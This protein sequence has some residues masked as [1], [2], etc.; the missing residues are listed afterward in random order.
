VAF[1]LT[2]G[3]AAQHQFFLHGPDR[4]FLA[5]VYCERTKQAGK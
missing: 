2:A 1:L 4:G 3:L 5:G